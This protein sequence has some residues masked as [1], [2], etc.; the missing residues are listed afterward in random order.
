[1]RDLQRLLGAEH[2]GEMDVLIIGAGGATRGLIG[3]FRQAGLRRI[4][5]ANRSVEKA[6][7]LATEM[8]APEGLA[9]KFSGAPVIGLPLASLQ[10]PTPPDG[11]HWPTLIINATAASLQ[12]AGLPLHPEIFGRSRL[13]VDLMYGPKAEPF[14]AQARAAGATH[15]ADGLGMLVEQAAESYF[16]WT[17]HKPETE[18]VLASLRNA[19]EPVTEG[20]SDQ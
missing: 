13:I 6:T 2:L 12:G 14:L 8:N 5:L 11:S 3:P 7:A 10:A 1:V 19:D 16:L 20:T 9:S 15:C 17:G 18:P 4:L